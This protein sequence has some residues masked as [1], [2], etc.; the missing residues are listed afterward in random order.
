MGGWVQSTPT[1]IAHHQHVKISCSG[2]TAPPTAKQPNHQPT[3]F[4]S[5]CHSSSAIE[6]TQ[7]HDYICSLTGEQI[8]PISTVTKLDNSLSLSPPYC[9][10][11]DGKGGKETLENLFLFE[12]VCYSFCSLSLSICLSPVGSKGD[13]GV[14]DVRLCGAPGGICQGPAMEP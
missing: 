12:F 3:V 11:G 7:S 9:A 8:S 1:R 2:L 10:E 4:T 14:V 6:E 5:D 13:D